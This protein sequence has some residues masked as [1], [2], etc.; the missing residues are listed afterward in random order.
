[1][2]S[3]IVD[4]SERRAGDGSVSS[5]NGMPVLNETYHYIVESDSK[6]TPR[7][8]ILYGTPSLPKVGQTVSAYGL[9]L[10][11][12]VKADRREDNPILW[13]VSAIFSSEVEEGQDGASGGQDPAVDPVT[14]VPVY[15]T[16][17]ERLQEVVTKDYAGTSI[18]NSAGQAFQTGLTIGRFIPV[19]EFWQFEAATITDEQLIARNET[20][21]DAEFKGRAIKSLLLTIL[22]SRVS[23]YYGQKRRLTH[24]SLKYNERLWTHKRL[25]VGTVYLDTGALKPYLDADGRTVILGGLNG[26]GAR[27]TAGNPPSVLSFDIYQSISFSFLRV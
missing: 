5:S 17:F 22:S 18:A 10:C 19:W 2:A 9:A 13:D 3:W 6:Y 4:G 11:V 20:V 27:V 7:V 21:N 24:Y 23:Y 12:S 15:E 1:M 8:D 26:S 25:D 14:W 16:K